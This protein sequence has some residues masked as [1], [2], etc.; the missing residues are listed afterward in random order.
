VEFC[1]SELDGAN[2][3]KF[4]FID[5][6][7]AIIRSAQDPSIEGKLYHTFELS[8]DKDGM[9]IFDKVNSGLV[10]ESFYLLDTE[11]S[12]LISIVASDASH[13]GHMVQHPLYRKS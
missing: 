5:L 1:F 13:Q 7:E 11:V 2:K 10:F 9:R 8:Q 4:Y 3:L 12:P 6:I